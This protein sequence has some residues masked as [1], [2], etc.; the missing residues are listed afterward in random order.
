MSLTLQGANRI[1]AR[2]G[3]GSGFEFVTEFRLDFGLP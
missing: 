1:S 3:L 2:S